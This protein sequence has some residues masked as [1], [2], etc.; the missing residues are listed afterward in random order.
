[1]MSMTWRQDTE[2]VAEQARSEHP[3]LPLALIG[4]SLGGIVAT[5]FAQQ[6]GEQLAALVLSGPAIG[7]N[8]GISALVDLPELPDVPIDPSWLSRDPEVGRRYAE[9]ELVYHGPFQRATL[10]ALVAAVTQ[11]AEGGSLGALP[12]LWIHGEEDPL[13]PLGPARDAIERIRGAN[14]QERVYSGARHEI[15]NEINQ[16]E[17]IA[18]MIAFL[19]RVLAVTPASSGARR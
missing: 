7:G 6:H 13:V 17:V 14:L 19:G 3:E 8:P 2:R 18:D 4:H 11:V 10:E 15:F 1:M 12:T 5:R 16:D 9:D